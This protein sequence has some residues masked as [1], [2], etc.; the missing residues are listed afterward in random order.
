MAILLT[1]GGGFLGK[2]LTPRL[3]QKGHKVY[4]LSRH[5][6]EP[7]ENL[8]P[9]VGDI[10]KPN[11]GLEEVPEDIRA[12]VHCAA[13]LS[14]R[15]KDRDR[16]YSTN[17]QGTINLLELMVRYKISRLFHVSTAYL[18]KQN[19]YEISK[20]MAEEAIRQYPQIRTTILR[21]SIIIGDSKV[22][23]LPP[24]S[25]FYLGVRAIDRAKR[26]F[27]A[28]TGA[29]PFRL[30]IRIQGKRT[31]R[32]NLIPVDIIVS[33]IIDIINQDKTG[34]FYLTHPNPPT[35]KSLEKSISEATGANIKVASR[36]KPNP[37]ERLASALMKGLKPYMTGTKLPSDI[38]CQPLTEEFLTR[39][40]RAFLSAS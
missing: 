24:L 15:A 36:F 11:L 30:K 27:E 5:P 19:H 26:W 33:S 16:L 23:G 12:V 28:R 34:V 21:P 32:L 7:A 25:G 9:L 13:L 37:V 1:G 8:T 29:W 39:T 6:P 22:E 40:I 10:T 18:F 20:E 31:G 4:S 14:F 38:D 35:F 2:A 17:Y 3:L